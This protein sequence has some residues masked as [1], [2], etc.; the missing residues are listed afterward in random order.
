MKVNIDSGRFFNGGAEEF[1][2]MGI[3]VCAVDLNGGYVSEEKNMKSGEELAESE[4]N[5]RQRFSLGK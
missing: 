1:E 5:I 3:D 4:E 2:K